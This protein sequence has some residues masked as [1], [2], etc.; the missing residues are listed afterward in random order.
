MPELPEVE[1]FRR[2]LDAKKPRRAIAR[3]EVRKTYLLRTPADVLCKTLEGQRLGRTARRGKELFVRLEPSQ[4]W[5]R[6]HFGMDG[7]WAFGRSAEPLPKWAVLVLDFEDGQRVC[8]TSFRLLGVLGIVADA[9]A[10]V[11]ERGLGPDAF[12]ASPREV[13]AALRAKRGAIKAA[14][15]DQGCLAGVGNLY[16]D[17]ALFQAGL[18]PRAPLQRLDD[19]ALRR[20]VGLLQRILATAV[21]KR[22]DFAAYPR[23]WLMPHR[24][25]GGTCPKDGAPLRRSVVG[26]RTTLHCPEH[27]R[28]PRGRSGGGPGKEKR[29]ARGAGPR[30]RSGAALRG[31]TRRPR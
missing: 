16:A 19:A 20:F 22:A 21:Q 12:E 17:E 3:A 10:W 23:T 15:L 30:A 6:V 25:I 4:Q 11:R 28:L 31:A 14:L 7:D 24:E 9:E 1:T 18:H 13:F 2:I 8:Y 27:Q 29:V 5:L 26:G